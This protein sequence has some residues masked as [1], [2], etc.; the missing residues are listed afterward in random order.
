MV[1]LQHPVAAYSGPSRTPSGQVVMTCLASVS[2]VKYFMK[3]PRRKHVLCLGPA[4]A[5]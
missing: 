3:P 5:I 2:P 4:S 1:D